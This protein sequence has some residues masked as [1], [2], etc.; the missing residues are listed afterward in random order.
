MGKNLASLWGA[1]AA[2]PDAPALVH[3]AI[4]RSWRELDTRAAG[5]RRLGL[6]R[7]SKLALYLSN[8]PEYLECTYGAFNLQA[9]PVKSIT[10][11]SPAARPACRRL[12]RR[13]TRR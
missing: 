4:R 10:A 1:A 3:G 13:T 6:T 8:C 7:D 11:T 2:V 9:I 5:L 12:S